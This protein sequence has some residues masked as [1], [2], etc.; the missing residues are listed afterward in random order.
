MNSAMATIRLIQCRNFPIFNESP[1][2]R[3][4]DSG[5]LSFQIIRTYKVEE[6]KRFVDPI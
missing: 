5:H 6:N 2:W 4:A 3:K 1:Q